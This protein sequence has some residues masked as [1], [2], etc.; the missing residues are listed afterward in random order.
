MQ[1]IPSLLLTLSLLVVAP[2][3]SFAASQRMSRAEVAKLIHLSY[4]EVFI[5]EYSPTDPY[6]IP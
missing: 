5:E 3:A 6:F 4:P 2:I 1:K